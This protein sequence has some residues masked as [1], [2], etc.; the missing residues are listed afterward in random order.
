VPQVADGTDQDMVKA[1]KAAKRLDLSPR[2]VTRAIANGEI[3]GKQICGI[4]LVNAAWLA[5]VTSWTPEAEA[6]A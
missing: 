4:Y 2:T 3:P 6:A 5:S 1:A